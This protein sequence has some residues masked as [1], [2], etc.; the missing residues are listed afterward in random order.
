MTA[1][2]L[3][4]GVEATQIDM[5]CAYFYLVIS[6]TLRGAEWFEAARALCL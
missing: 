3:A 4:N 6:E 2:Q 1:F 5:F